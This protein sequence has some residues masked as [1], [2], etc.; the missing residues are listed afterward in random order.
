ME[1]YHEAVDVVGSCL[2][3]YLGSYYLGGGEIMA[4]LLVCPKCGSRKIGKEREEDDEYCCDDCL[5][6][7][8]EPKEIIAGEKSVKKPGKEEEKMATDKEKLKELHAQGKSDKEIA[9]AL[10]A[11]V[12]TVWAARNALGLKANYTLKRS[13]GRSI[14]RPSRKSSNHVEK[15]EKSPL[16]KPEA[17]ADITAL[18]MLLAER[19]GL[20]NR[21]F[22]INQAIELLS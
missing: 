8:A 2:P 4:G 16:R 6:F 18:D 10:N 1:I 3:A 12:G 13:P 22:K 20:Q 14:D 17:L 9:E 19:N 5:E 11:K 21:I 15:L 7:F